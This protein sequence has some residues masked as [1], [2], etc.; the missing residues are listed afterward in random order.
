MTP[1]RLRL[2]M[3]GGGEGS[4]IGGVHRMAARLDD[5]FELVAGAFSSDADCSRRSGAALGLS[6][7]RVYGSFEQMAKAEAGRGDSIDVV[8]VVTPNDSHFAICRAF[9]QCGIPVICD[10]PLTTTLEDAHAL[11]GIVR[12]RKLPFIVTHTYSGYPMVRQ[13][14]AMVAEGA[15][16]TIRVVQIEYPQDWLATSIER[17][18]QKQATWRTDP[19]RSGPA[20]CV[21]DIGTHAYHLA[22]YVT[23]LRV[24]AISADLS[25]FVPGRALDDNAGMLLRFAGGA[26]GMLWCSQVAIGHENGLRLR[27]YG[28]R[29]GLEWAQESPNQL[30]FTVYGEA[31]QVQYR[32]MSGL[33]PAATHASRV[34]SGHPEGYLEAFA[35]LYADAASVLRAASQGRT[36]EAMRWLPGIEDGVRGMEFIAA[37]LESNSNDARW[38]AIRG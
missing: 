4:F 18:G 19:A 12:E 20:G 30:R 15:L 6:P 1:R 35:Q 5:Q 32:G 34:P 25:S 8:S 33:S 16:G 27:V 22:G 11:A 24:Q 7:E 9:L 23:G 28:E 26:R 3:V 13:A 17:T 10:K 31:P 29:A 38:T 37:A 14:Q 36:A 2:G 21:G